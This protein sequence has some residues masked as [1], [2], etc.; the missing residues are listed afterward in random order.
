[1]G[2]AGEGASGE[3]IHNSWFWGD[4]GMGAYEFNIK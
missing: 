4:M 1:M 2:A 3:V